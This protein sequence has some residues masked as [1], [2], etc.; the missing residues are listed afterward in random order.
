MHRLPC[1][2]NSCQLR[3]MQAPGIGLWIF[4]QN[5]SLTHKILGAL[6]RT[7]RTWLDI[8]FSG[9]CSLGMTCMNFFSDHPP[10]YLKRK[11]K[12]GP[13]LV[14]C[15][16]GGLKV[17]GGC[18]IKE[19]LTKWSERSNKPLHDEHGSCREL[20]ASEGLLNW[21]ASSPKHG[22]AT[23]HPSQWWICLLRRSGADCLDTSLN[24]IFLLAHRSEYE[25]DFHGPPIS[26]PVR[27]RGAAASCSN[28]SQQSVS[29]CNY[30][31]CRSSQL[32]FL[33]LLAKDKKY[34]WFLTTVIKERWS[35][36]HVRVNRN[37]KVAQCKIETYSDSLYIKFHNHSCLEVYVK[38]W[39]CIKYVYT[40]EPRS[41]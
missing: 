20:T 19:G 10:R 31:S 23:A 7:A 27:E 38:K 32:L 41:R 14:W 13:T 28:V 12:G 6:A 39:F 18:L 36:P 29:E 8:S 4:T 34:R 11:Y 24:G 22:R 5:P 25:M 16:T 33:H 30:P 9:Y 3:D 35:L 40:E 17:W 21:T 15:G 26:S 37:M 2:R 1:C